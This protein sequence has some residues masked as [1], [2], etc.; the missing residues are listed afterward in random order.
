MRCYRSPA[1][2]YL[3]HRITMIAKT[4]RPFAN[5]YDLLRRAKNSVVNWSFFFPFTV[6]FCSSQS[7]S[8]KPF[9][10]GEI[11]PDLLVNTCPQIASKH[12]FSHMLLSFY[13]KKK[14]KNNS[15]NL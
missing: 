4:I 13:L 10:R 5:K 6:F 7:Q 11:R 12:F 3:A 1:L 9:I 8:F 15:N 14:K 2:Y